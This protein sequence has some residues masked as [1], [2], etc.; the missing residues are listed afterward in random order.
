MCEASNYGFP[1]YADPDQGADQDNFEDSGSVA[2]NSR[3]KPRKIN[4]N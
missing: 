1:S 3:V 2:I 4:V